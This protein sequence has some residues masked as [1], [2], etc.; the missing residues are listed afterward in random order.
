MK[1]DGKKHTYTDGGGVDYLARMLDQTLQST[2]RVDIEK[3]QLIKKLVKDL[4][5]EAYVNDNPE[6]FAA[7]LAKAMDYALHC[8]QHQ[9]PQYLSSVFQIN[10]QDNHLRRAR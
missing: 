7:I 6:A 10:Y 2:Q 4:L 9:M 1:G 5:K 3:V 8:H